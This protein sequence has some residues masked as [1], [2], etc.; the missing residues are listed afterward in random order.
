[1]SRDQPTINYKSQKGFLIPLALFIVVVL[2]LLAYAIT[3]LTGSAQNLALREAIATEAL[4][5]AESTA[6]IALYKLFLNAST[7]A[8]TTTNCSAINNTTQ[9]FTA[10][11]LKGCSVLIT[12]AVTTDAA[13]T[14]S[15][16]RLTQAA[17][18][19]SDNLSGQ[20]TIVVSAVMQ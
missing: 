14:K 16:Y 12:C 5:A 7:R 3:R 2:G 18:C 4:F 20:R 13:N 10:T 1:M 17:S 6:N 15:F 8:Q 11:G 19:G 9:S